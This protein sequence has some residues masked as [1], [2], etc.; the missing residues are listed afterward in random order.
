MLV[1]GVCIFVANIV[2]LFKHYTHYWMGTFFFF[3][4]TSSYFFFF[5]LFSISFKNEVDHL[6]MPTFS[7]R[8]CYLIIFFVVFSVY[9]A[10]L[11]YSSCKRLTKG[12]DK[13]M[14]GETEELLENQQ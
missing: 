9:L 1:Y 11:A 3:L 10:E 12:V 5:W 13:D 14:D 8:I 7:M 2:L 4:C 6:F